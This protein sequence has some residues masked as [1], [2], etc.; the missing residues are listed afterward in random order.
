MF[1]PYSLILGLFTVMGLATT[2]WGWLVIVRAR[3]TARWPHVSGKIET[4]TMAADA[5]ELL[6][7]IQFSYTL[8]DKHYRKS[9]EFPSGTTPTL[10]LSESYVNKFPSGA[11]VDVYY[12][13]DHTEQATLEPGQRPGDWMI[14]AFGLGT[15]LLMVLI[16]LLGGN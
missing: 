5:D 2:L 1:N 7:D 16:L 9:I 6:P 14:L 13:P 12:H 10:Q 8:A 3:E 4:S 11:T 15:T